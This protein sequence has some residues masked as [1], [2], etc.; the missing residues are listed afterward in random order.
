M[1]VDAGPSTTDSAAATAPRQPIVYSANYSSV[2]VWEIRVNGID[3]MRRC[4]DNWLNSTQLLKVADIDKPQRTKILEREIQTGVHEKVQGGYGK[5]QGTWVPF[6]RGVEIAEQFGVKDKV[7]AILTFRPETDPVPPRAPPKRLSPSKKSLTGKTSD[8]LSPSPSPRRVRRKNV[9]MLPG[10]GGGTGAGT[11]MAVDSP[12]GV[13]PSGLHTITSVLSGIASVDDNDMDDDPSDSMYTPYARDRARPRGAELPSGPTT[14]AQLPLQQHAPPLRA[15]TA[16]SVNSIAYFHNSPRLDYSTARRLEDQ[17]ADDGGRSDASESLLQHYQTDDADTQPHPRPSSLSYPY[18]KPARASSPA[19]P[20]L[21][22]TAAS[23][24]ASMASTTP[25]S[26]PTAAAQQRRSRNSPQISATAYPHSH[27]MDSISLARAAHANAYAYQGG[28]A[29]V[30]AGAGSTDTRGESKFVAASPSAEGFVSVHLARWRDTLI[31]QLLQRKTLPPLLTASMSD[32][33][34]STPLDDRGNTVLHWSAALAR[35]DCC[36]CLLHTRRMPPM[37]ATL[38]EGITALMWAVKFEDNYKHAVFADVLNL[39]GDVCLRV[40]DV[41]GQTVLHH[42]VRAAGDPGKG[43]AA[44]YYMDC[45]VQRLAVGGGSSSSNG[46]RGQMMAM[47]KMMAGDKYAKALLDTQDRRGNT[48]LHIATREGYVD[49]CTALVK[50]GADVT[51]ANKRGQTHESL[52]RDRQG[53]DAARAETYRT[54]AV[55]SSARRMPISASAGGAAAG[56]GV[57]GNNGKRKLVSSVSSLYGR[58]YATGADSRRRRSLRA[59]SPREHGAETGNESA[60]ADVESDEEQVTPDHNSPTSSLGSG[61][62]PPA[63]VPAPQSKTAPS[64]GS[65]DINSHKRHKPMRSGSSSMRVSQSISSSVAAAGSSTQSR[66]SQRQHAP[67]ARPLPAQTAPPQSRP[68]RPLGSAAAMSATGPHGAAAAARNH[69]LCSQLFSLLNQQWQ[70]NEQVLQNKAQQVRQQ[71]MRM[72]DILDMIDTTER[73]LHSR[74]PITAHAANVGAELEQL[75]ARAKSELRR[76]LA[77]TLAQQ[78]T[79]EMQTDADEEETARQQR[80]QEQLLRDIVEC[81]SKHESLAAL[82][83]VVQ[84]VARAVGTT[85]TTPLPEVHMKGMLQSGPSTSD[86]LLSAI[87]ERKQQLVQQ[88]LRLIGSACG[89]GAE[90]VDVALLEELESLSRE[91]PR[92]RGAAI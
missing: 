12:G 69:A 42:I 61:S 26:A 35:L 2:P 33:P 39:F 8:G 58:E 75:C 44:R 60:F 25:A 43:R 38:D 20:G 88:Y 9:A 41:H 19:P 78:D 13:G 45:V 72:K 24:S 62:P 48:A 36:R 18:S 82:S 37:T 70:Q 89:V 1:S 16:G 46:G 76:W 53:M 92:P 54:L 56:S 85:T 74:S 14:S 57:T 5:Y 22:L 91:A 81:L 50:A 84:A 83:D 11:A 17:D 64:S 86:A 31:Q 63:S 10:S 79:S 73:E 80:E 30:T 71:Q 27:P 15:G 77:D 87:V 28:G 51:L 4:S 21:S 59:G 23:N 55:M 32:Y 49:I 66:Q 67:Q 65:N 34:L 90:Q 3:V 52:L 68:P 40:T 29:T 47:S 7:L 6:D